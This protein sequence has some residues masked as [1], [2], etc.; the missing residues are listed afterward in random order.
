MERAVEKIAFLPF[1][2]LMDR[3]RWDVFSGKIKPDRY[4][5][6]WWQLR[7]RYQGI[8][9]PVPRGGEDFDP[10][11][12][13]HIPANVPYTRYFL[14]TVLQFQFHRAL[15]KVAGHEGPLHTCSIYGNE[16]AGARLRAMMEM[17]LSHPWPKALAALSGETKMD[18][19]AI[20]DYFAPLQAWLKKQNEGQSCGW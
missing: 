6:A 7:Q 19:S 15:C 2:L 16:A 17:G 1:G 13:Y 5:E 11:A 8:A 3:W 12:K 4:N 9:A 10:G 14:A 20:L 18:V